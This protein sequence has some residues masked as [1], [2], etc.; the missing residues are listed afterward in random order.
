VKT[1]KGVI[2]IAYK[3]RMKPRFVVLNRSKNWEGWELPKGH[4]EDDDYRETVKLELKE[5]AGIIE[6]HIKEISDLDH[7]VEWT[8]EDD[9][10]EIR[11]EY[12]AFIVELSEDAFIDV[13][14]NPHDEHD[15]GFFFREEDA[16][17]LLTY[18]NN[19]K[20]LEKAIE[21]IEN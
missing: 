16:K 12:S 10:E 1:E 15:Q 5:E 14:A 4:L 7:I 17:S 2:I 19:I 13:N 8:F 6:E 21:E 11:R 9:G 20:V 18:D 3:D